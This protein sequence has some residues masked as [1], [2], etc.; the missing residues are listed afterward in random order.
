MFIGGDPRLSVTARTLVEDI[1]NEVF[2][3]VASLW[4][5]AIKVSLG[6][7]QLAQPFDVL[8]PQQLSL[9]HIG[10]LGITVGHVAQVAVLPFYHRDPFDRLRVAQALVDG[11]VLVSRGPAFDA[12]GLT[13]FW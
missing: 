11:M 2:L 1:G 12:Y 7:L 3:S 13:R 5:I 8:I 6:R 4:E 10:L 9:N